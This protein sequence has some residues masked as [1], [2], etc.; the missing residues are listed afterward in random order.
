MN[1]NTH[2]PR[3]LISGGGIAGLTAAYWLHQHGFIPTVIEK[4]PHIRTE[5]HV[6]DFSGTGWTV[7]ECMGLL[8]GL[9]ERQ[10]NMPYLIFKN[11][12]GRTIARL[13]VKAMSATF[14]HRYV[15]ITR[16]DLQDLLYETVRDKVEICFDTTI[17]AL[18]ATAAGVQLL[19]SNGTTAHFDLVIGAD[20]IHSRTRELLWGA[21][22]QFARYLGYY[23][24]IYY[25]PSQPDY[26]AG[27]M[28]YMEP[29]RQIGVLQQNDGR[30][31]VFVIFRAD[32]AGHV[33]AAE[34]REMILCHYQGM[35][36]IAAELLAHLPANGDFYFDRVTQ[37]LLPTWSRGRVALIG[38]AAHCL[39]LISGQG[40]SMAMGGAYLLA[41]ALAE[42]K[43][44]YAA[45]FAAY[46]QRFRP[47]IE[48]KQNQA[49]RIARAFVPRT[50][51]GA[52][53]APHLM[54]LAFTP[55]FGRF[56]GKQF[57]E[58]TVLNSS[59]RS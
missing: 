12:D 34:R 53:L 52:K 22:A 24:A 1:S 11:S 40:A 42:H 33:P 45:A 10:Q 13:S 54:K 15:P 39:S 47:H 59:E 49:H 41:Q 30:G 38:D 37:I 2:S 20:G 43:D 46:E 21:E 50:K 29:H 51:L 16:Y 57:G 44:D 32:D 36:W 4:A 23:T 28:N 18:E 14:D 9:R 8:P 5:G 3:I 26:A 58:D 31:M 56:F 55:P 27:F 6:I 17:Q 25:I 19:L 7:S 35:G 48:Q